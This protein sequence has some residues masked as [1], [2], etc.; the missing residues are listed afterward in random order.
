ML[1]GRTASGR[2]PHHLP[3]LPIALVAHNAYTAH[4]RV[5]CFRR[6]CSSRVAPTSRWRATKATPPSTSPRAT[7]TPRCCGCSSAQPSSA[8]RTSSAR[9]R[10]TWRGKRTIGGAWLRWRRRA[11]CHGALCASHQLARPGYVPQAYE[12][13]LSPEVT[14]P[15][16]PLPKNWLDGDYGN[17]QKFYYN[18]FS[19]ETS[20]T[21]P[22]AP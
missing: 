15:P 17:G 12:L 19:G 6:S 4:G 10:S 14:D 13:P 3:R 9:L 20:E 21:R 11:D 1:P 8:R 2:R 22:A 16:S 7:A 18:P 5:G